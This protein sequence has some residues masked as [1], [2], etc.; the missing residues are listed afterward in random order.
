VALAGRMAQA[1][2]T[3]TRG[4]Y[5]PDW[6]I[7]RIAARIGEITDRTRTVTFAPVPSG[8]YDHL[9]FSFDMA[10]NEQ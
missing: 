1:Y 3:E 7:E 8:F 4:A 2:V 5:D 6:S 10:R 9:G